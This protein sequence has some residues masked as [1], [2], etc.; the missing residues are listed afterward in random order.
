MRPWRRACIMHV[1]RKQSEDEAGPGGVVQSSK[2][3]HPPTS[4]CKYI[5][6]PHV[7]IHPETP[8]IAFCRRVTRRRGFP[9]TALVVKLKSPK[10]NS[11]VNRFDRATS[12][13]A[14]RSN[15]QQICLS[16]LR[17]TILNSRALPHTIP[18]QNPLAL[19]LLQAPPL[20]T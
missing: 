9:L 1:S 17:T 8:H 2:R 15:P 6:S 14:R 5:C 20:A 7:Y 3:K 16:P 19:Q 10:A 18:P 11:C 13:L 12:F 4:T